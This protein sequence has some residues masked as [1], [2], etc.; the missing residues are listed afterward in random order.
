MTVNKYFRGMLGLGDSIYQR[1]FLKGEKNQI[2]FVTSWPEL[3]EDL[4]N[5]IPVKPATNLRTQKKNADKYQRWQPA[6]QATARP[7][8]YG[9][10]GIIKGLS[11]SFGKKA[12]E[13]DL[14]DFGESPVDG[15]YVVVRPVTLREEWKAVSRNP[16]P[17]YIEQSVNAIKAKGLKVVSVADLEEGKEWLV[18]N[19][20]NA[21]IEFHKGELTI[22]QLMALCANAKALIGGV[23]WIVP[24]SLAYKVPAWVVLGGHGTF[25]HPKQL[26]QIDYPNNSITWAMP[27][28]FCMCRMMAHD[29]NKTISDYSEKLSRWIEKT[30]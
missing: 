23:G 16:K 14:P 17:Q 10:H 22:K 20:I 21:D 19:Q 30:L 24:T 12:C 9:T 4:P 6:P 2:Y 5:V 7:I 25:N 26:Q 13:M 29:C 28:E 8:S 3:Y 27:D 15:D 18:G 1:A 11:L